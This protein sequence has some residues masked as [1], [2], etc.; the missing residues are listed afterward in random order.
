MSVI[1]REDKNNNIIEFRPLDK[2]YRYKVNGETKRGVTTLIGARFGKAPLMLWAKK[3]PLTALEWQLESEGKSKDYIYNFIDGLKK[4]IAE[5]E[6][7]DATTGT[8][9]HSYCEDYI[10]GKNVV[11]PTTEPLITMFDKFTKW[12]DSRDY[13]VLATEQTCY[14]KDLDVCG[15]FD[16]IVQNKKGKNVLLDFKTSKD[17]YPD[18][19]IQI[20]TYKKLIE[21]S[22]NLKIDSYGIIKIPKDPTQEVSLRMYKPE[23][24]YL[25]GFKACKF[26]DS[27]ERDFLKKTKEYN[28]L[29]KGKKHVSK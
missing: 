19:P 25:K 10:N 9:M 12:W 4:K 16:V 18:Q 7:K 5:L 2:R 11:P 29:K 6:I 22:T 14:S 21:D 3:L 27:F 26:L 15:T 24:I 8:L 23:S 1:T 17:F 20:A 28:K 13:K